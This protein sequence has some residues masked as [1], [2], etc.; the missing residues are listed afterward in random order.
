MIVAII[1]SEANLKNHAVSD[2]ARRLPLA[3]GV[4]E[5]EARSLSRR[6]RSSSGSTAAPCY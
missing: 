1:S 5:P 2:I 3:R 4:S 6:A